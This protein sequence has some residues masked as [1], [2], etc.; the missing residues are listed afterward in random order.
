[1]DLNL[2]M[3]YS[4][5]PVQAGRALKR[6]PALPI[7]SSAGVFDFSLDVDIASSTTLGVIQVGSGLSITPAG[8][9]SATGGGG[10]NFVNVKLVSN[11]YT[12]TAS[13]LYVGATDD[14][15]TI[16]LPIGILGRV[17]Y[18]KNQSGGNIQLQGTSGQ[19]IDASTSKTLGSN[20]G[21]IVVFDGSRWNTV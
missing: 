2:I 10:S 17:Y 11:N 19:T 3:S 20:S 15:I 12:A 8:I 6:K 5:P 4:R 9:L 7:E 13:D 14:H 18:I 16:I 1:M 21:I